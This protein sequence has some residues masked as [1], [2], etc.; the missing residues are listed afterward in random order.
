MSEVKIFTKHEIKKLLTMDMAIAA[1]ERAFA[2]QSEGKAIMP[3]K[4][5]L[6][7]PDG[8]GDFRAMPGFINGMAG[9]KWVSVYPNNPKSSLPTVSAII[10]LSDY[11]TGQPLAIMD[12]TYITEIRT[13]AAGGVAAKYLARKNSSI[14]GILGAGTQAE[15]QLL[16]LREIFPRL[17]QIKIFDLNTEASSKF[18]RKL[19]ERLGV[20]IHISR[21][22]AEI[23]DADIL[24]T[25]T[26]SRRPVIGGNQ[27][28][29]GTHINAIGADAPGKQELDPYILKRAKI[30]VDE[31]EQA[32]HSGEINVPLSLGL[33]NRHHIW[34]TLGE[35]ITG[36]KKGREN[37]EEITVF[38]STGLA[39]QDIICANE[40]YKSARDSEILTLDLLTN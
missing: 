35:V 30:V 23:A 22:V 34:G 5:Y 26:P 12:G 13:G 3:P 32:S 33:L 15:K 8:K 11:E 36:M 28:K 7:F 10:I 17:N 18:A 4:L 20:E 24:V 38:D 21:S 16:A 31:I 29:S 39:I 6:D 25:T 14:V 9:M 2:L 37:D 19:T 1:V 27:V 40:V